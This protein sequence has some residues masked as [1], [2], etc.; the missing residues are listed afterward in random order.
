MICC[1]G[2]PVIP[3]KCD[4]VTVALLEHR[5]AAE[6]LADDLTEYY[7]WTLWQRAMWLGAPPG[8]IESLKRYGI[9]LEPENEG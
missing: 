3:L 4:W 8:S 6:R 2:S 5:E 1:D 9:T 7:G